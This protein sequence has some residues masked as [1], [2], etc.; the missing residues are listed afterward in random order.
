M[1]TGG[2]ESDESGEG[3]SHPHQVPELLQGDAEKGRGWGGQR[4]RLAPACMKRLHWPG[5]CH[6]ALAPVTVS[7]TVH[8]AQ[9]HT[10]PLHL[11]QGLLWWM[12]LLRV[13]PGGH[14]SPSAL[15]WHLKSFSCVGRLSLFFQQPQTG[16]G[17]SIGSGSS[18]LQQQL[19][20]SQESTTPNTN[21]KSARPA[22]SGFSTLLHS[23][24][25]KE[26]LPSH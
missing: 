26:A 3:C 15:H 19:L 16:L 8:A 6:S 25:L 23:V 11:A 18:A 13:G 1:G 14:S 4:R 24:S 9:H 20:C 10:G 5:S 12:L 17:L 21:A 22:G 7:W 2:W